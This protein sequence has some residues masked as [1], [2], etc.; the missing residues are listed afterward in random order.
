MFSWR[1][2][3]AAERVDQMTWQPFCDIGAA[4]LCCPVVCSF[5]LTDSL[6]I[7]RL[8]FSSWVRKIPWTREWLPTPVFLSGKFHRQEPGGLQSMGLQRVGHDWATNTCTRADWRWGSRFKLRGRQNWPFWLL[9]LPGLWNESIPWLSLTALC[10]AA[11]TAAFLVFLCLPLE[12]QVQ[13]YNLYYSLY[14]CRP[15]LDAFYIP[16]SVGRASL[17]AQW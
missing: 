16:E 17:A 4:I 10:V 13:N 8:Y 9:I 6:K 12:T 15:I 3:V 11:I 14:Q 5:F 1:C 2:T 7:Y